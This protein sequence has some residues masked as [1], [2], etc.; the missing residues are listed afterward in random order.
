MLN[1]N[2]AMMANGL[3][4]LALFTYALT[5]IPSSLKIVYPVIHKQK[6]IVKLLQKRR[7]L[8]I[9]T[10]LI[11]LG[12]AG[13]FIVNRQRDFYNWKNY[14][15]YINGIAILFIFTLLAVTSNNWSVK[16]MKKNWRYL[17]KLTYV[18]LFL[19]LWH[20][21][22]KMSGHWTCITPL[23]LGTITAAITFFLLRVGIYIVSGDVGII[24]SRHSKV[25]DSRAIV[26]KAQSQK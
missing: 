17:H 20:V 3:G 15:T 14:P 13:L 1:L 23:A 6:I 19:L 22:E 10:F 8:G 9:V 5:L 12:H 4:L 11:S 7:Q 2:P 25:W 21:D 24:F 18:A 26:T 16:K